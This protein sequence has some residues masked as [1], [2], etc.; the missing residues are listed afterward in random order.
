MLLRFS[1]KNL[2][3]L[4]FLKEFGYV[5][6]LDMEKITIFEDISMNSMKKTLQ[7]GGMDTTDRK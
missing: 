4:M 5:D 2:D 7:N 6:P 3:K 1:T